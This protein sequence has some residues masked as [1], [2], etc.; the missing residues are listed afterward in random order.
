VNLELLENVVDMVFDCCGTNPQPSGD[1]LIW[2]VECDESRHFA[3][4]RCQRV[5]RVSVDPSFRN[6]RQSAEK[7][8]GDVRRAHQLAAQR[9]HNRRLQILKRAVLRDI[10]R[11][12]GLGTGQDMLFG[13]GDC[14]GD[15]FYRGKD[16]FGAV[17][18][19][20][21][22]GGG[23]FEEHDL[24]PQRRDPIDSIL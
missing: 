13:L 21:A 11:D 5:I 7:Q 15:N 10:S 8:R 4:A 3:F 22:V 19:I 1:F 9:A 18:N 6:R 2:K 14:E 23:E 17:R 12:A 24:R 20:Q 16:L